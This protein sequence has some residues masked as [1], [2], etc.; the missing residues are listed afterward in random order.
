[1]TIDYSGVP[2]N[3]GNKGFWD[4][5]KD[6]HKHSTIRLVIYS[7]Y[8]EYCDLIQDS[9]DREKGIIKVRVPQALYNKLKVTDFQG[10]FWYL[11]TDFR[12]VNH[13]TVYRYDKY[14][15]ND[16]F[17]ITEVLPWF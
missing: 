11:G 10:L 13:W 14:P 4:A 3:A 7:P 1:M 8:A 5:M 15:S 6:K 9:T 16:Y 17:K 2:K 12:Y